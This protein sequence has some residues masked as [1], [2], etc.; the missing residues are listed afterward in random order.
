MTTKIFKTSNEL[1]V[2]YYKRTVGEKVYSQEGNSPECKLRSLNFYLVNEDY[3]N[4]KIR[5]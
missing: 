4:Y 5:M 3:L 1:D 2:I